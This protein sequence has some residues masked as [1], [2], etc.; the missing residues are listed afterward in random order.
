MSQLEVLSLAERGWRL[1]PCA[2]R[3]K[4][5]LIG[6][7]Q[8][9]ASCDPEMIR[10]WARRH[11]GCNW[12]LATGPKSKIWALDVD[13]EL[14]RESLSAL[15]A[16][17]GDD[18]T[19]TIA[20]ET[21]TGRH[22]YFSYPSE[23]LIRNSASKLAPGLDTR[24]DGGYVIVPP[25]IHPTGATY[26]WT[27]P[28]N[29]QEPRS[30]PEWLLQLVTSPE[31]AAIRPCDVNALYTGS[32]NDTL[33]RV[34]CYLRRKGFELEQICFELLDQNARRCRPPLPDED[35]YRL[36]RQAAAYPVGGP[37]FLETA[38]NALQGKAFVSNYAK[39]LALVHELQT[40]RPGRS[41]ALPVNRIG[42]LF[43]LHR[44]AIGSFRRQAV[45]DGVLELAEA[46]VAQ[47]KAAC[48]RVLGKI[49]DR[50]PET[51]SILPKLSIWLRES[52]VQSAH[53][54]S[55]V[56]AYRES[57]HRESPV[58]HRESSRFCYVHGEHS[59]FWLRGEDFICE[60]CHPNPFAEVN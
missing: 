19:R 59:N 17:Y 27:A 37:D 33:F 58:A 50:P 45:R 54:E 29:G 23:G 30:T 3:G 51:L 7:W 46:Y 22:F 60:L 21:A 35:I 49:E 25:S 13:G 36:A 40:A 14:G 2:E 18:W 41:I 55:S 9:R 4:I 20:V 11:P 26:Q 16:Q 38:W 8:R 56:V 34:G 15:T 6:Q 31:R 57:S 24:G 28:L 12:G 47:R 39:F 32:R 1:L 48:Y 52:S 53:R 10:S 44:T 43:G 42:E 5:A